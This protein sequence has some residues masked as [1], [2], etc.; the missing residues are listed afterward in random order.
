MME[1]LELLVTW[2]PY[3]LGGF[4]WNLAIALLAMGVGTALGCLFALARLSPRPLLATPAGWITA[5]FR[6]VSTLVLLFYLATLAPSELSLWA[7]GPVLLFPPWLKAGI[8]LAASP[9]GF[10]A[11]NLHASLVALAKGDRRS[12]LLFVPNWLASFL[13]T[14]LATSVSSLVGVSELVGRSATVI[15]AT[16]SQHML[17]IYLYA[18]AFFWIFGA[19]FG[20]TVD[21]IRQWLL[22]RYA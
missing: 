2:T 4:G 1:T 22:A 7:G 19:F 9:L 3:L 15:N 12:A 13:I 8:A 14:L 20:A 21:R 5:F 16:G 17:A 18:A 11:W 6:N 10:T